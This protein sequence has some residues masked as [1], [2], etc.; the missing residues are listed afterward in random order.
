MT[1]S[2][3]IFAA[4]AIAGALA[5]SGCHSSAGGG[6]SDVKILKR[7]PDGKPTEVHVDGKDWAVCTKNVTTNCLNPT[8]AG[9]N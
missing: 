4:L 3:P 5:L 2:R 1:R 8:A 9:L 7:G 6:Q